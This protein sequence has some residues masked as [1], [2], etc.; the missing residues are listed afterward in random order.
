MWLVVNFPSAVVIALKVLRWLLYVF[1]VVVL[2]GLAWLLSTREGTQFIAGVASQQLQELQLDDVEGY[3]LGDLTVGRLQWREESVV[4]TAHSVSLNWSPLCLLNN[5]LCIEPLYAA[6]LEITVLPGTEDDSP[7]DDGLPVISMPVGLVIDETHIKT[8]QLTIEGQSH[9]INGLKFSGRWVDTLLSL[10][11]FAASYNGSDLKGLGLSGKGELDFSNPWISQFVGRVDYPLPADISQQPLAFEFELHGRQLAFDIKGQ[12][13]GDWPAQLSS[14]ISF[15]DPRLPL[16]VSFDSPASWIVPLGS[17]TTPLDISQFSADA[18]LRDLSLEVE[19]RLKTA[20]WSELTVSLDAQWIEDRL[21]LNSATIDS[22]YGQLQLQGAWV[23]S[24]QMP[25]DFS[26]Q[27]HQLALHQISLPDS[28][29]PPVPYPVIFDSDW[30]I[31]GTASERPNISF[32][33]KRFAGQIN[34]YPIE[35]HAAFSYDTEMWHVKE[36]AASS[37]LNSLNISGS[38]GAN[39]KEFKGVEAHFDIPEPERWIPELKGAVEGAVSLDGSI[40]KADIS[41][42]V[43]SSKLNYDDISVGAIEAEFDIVQ[44]GFQPSMLVF[45]AEAL[46]YQGVEIESTDWQLKGDINGTSVKA[47]VTLS[48]T[49]TATAQCDLTWELGQG[50]QNFTP[51][52]KGQVESRCADVRWRSDTYPY[53]LLTVRN[54]TPIV[55]NWNFASKA[56]LIEPFC[57][58][59]DDVEICNHKDATWDPVNG[60][61]LWLNTEAQPLNQ[62]IQRW[63]VKGLADNRIENVGLQGELSGFAKISQKTGG[64]IDAEI[65][66]RVP[67]LDLL[68]Q[69]LRPQVYDSRSKHHL[70]DDSSPSVSIVFE[71]LTLSST[72]QNENITMKA[73]FSSPQLGDAESQMRLTDIA[74]KRL[75]E[76]EFSLNELNLNFMQPLLPAVETLKGLFSSQLNVAGSLNKPNLSGQFRLSDGE[77]K[78]DYLPDRFHKIGVEGEFSQQQ[79]DYSGSFKLSGGEASLSGN[80][81][82][83]QEWVLNTSLTSESFDITP[84]SGVNL[85]LKP[86][87]KL[88]LKQGF[89]DL[90]GTLEVPHARIKLDKLPEGTKSVSSDAVVIGDSQEDSN[91]SPWRYRADINLIL[92]DDVYFRGFGVNTYLTGRLL[93]RQRPGRELVGIGEIAT[94]DGFYTLFGQRL[95]VKEG[96]FIFNGPLD[97]P[98]LQLD[99]MR[100]IPSSAV[101]VGVKVTGPAAEPEVIFYSQP[102]MN[103]SSIIYYLLTGRPPDQK[104]NNSALLNNMVLSAGVFGTSDFTEKM[105]NKIGVTDLQISTQSDEEGTSLEVSGYV[106]PD[107]YLKYGTSLYDEAK[108]VAVRY[109]LQPNLFIEAAGGLSSSLDLIYQFEH[110]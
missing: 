67:K 2:I 49:G 4:V 47:G 84:R 96:L 39:G 42:R 78:S 17:E 31:S 74:K 22:K 40:E 79:L 45:S 57:L 110:R 7:A 3:V 38:L 1:G 69:R 61:S 72:M 16:S 11:D 63:N 13:S 87:L 107:I 9:I 92:G 64:T 62:L 95:T 109:R 91:A 51:P 54:K 29:T 105:A 65:A 101:K 23:T 10:S 85:K 18:S 81:N 41:G 6:R 20:Y 32:L 104:S 98:D 30:R 90:S 19:S 108:T 103:E 55:V 28:A 83:Q 56:L 68:L 34:Q 66:L 99:A 35:G 76:G 80:L 52:D 100:S 36:L 26:I 27:T 89:A 86:D 46:T 82:W 70:K 12:L 97:S 106:S 73:Q 37:G 33:L 58:V 71:P 8:L 43:T 48:D 44:S 14:T 59:D 21:Q 102:T 94:E 53:S 15:D 50:S 60:Y 25:F 88:Q 75:L 93:L 5:K 77:F 24:E